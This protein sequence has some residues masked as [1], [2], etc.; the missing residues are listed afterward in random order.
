MPAG[1]MRGV[2]RSG[3]LGPARSQEGQPWLRKVGAD[4]ARRVYEGRKVLG[5][6]S[7]CLGILPALSLLA[8]SL[9]LLQV[10]PQQ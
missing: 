2:H 10:H 5:P 4:D 9:E 7:T 6:G 1:C 8:F 3:V